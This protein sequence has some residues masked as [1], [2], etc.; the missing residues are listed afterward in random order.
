MLRR[1]HTLI[2]SK[3]TRLNLKGDI[4]NKFD[5]SA[6]PRSALRT[7]R[8]LISDKPPDR[9]SALALCCW[10]TAIPSTLTSHTLAQFPC[11]P[12]PQHWF[13]FYFLSFSPSL[14]SPLLFTHLL[15]ALS[16]NSVFFTSLLIFPL[17]RPSCLLMTCPSHAFT[18]S[19]HSS[20]EAASVPRCGTYCIYLYFCS[21]P[22][23][24]S[25]NTIGIKCWH[26][27][28]GILKQ[29]VVR[30]FECLIFSARC[31]LKPLK[32]FGNTYSTVAPMKPIKNLIWMRERGEK[33][34]KR[35]RGIGDTICHYFH[36]FRTHCDKN[37][38]T[39]QGVAHTGTLQT[40][41]YAHTHQLWVWFAMCSFCL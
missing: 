27:L 19:S 15:P 28:L 31:W 1:T 41:K 21:S 4:R 3:S 16:L 11:I 18:V 32:C 40:N 29:A 39:H 6:Y 14:F 26:D 35:G 25:F 17:L 13:F 34:K 10:F 9:I 8:N 38:Y 30:L 12:P 37:K 2:C 24:E 22:L 33:G 20:G 36:S 5:T 23:S 7:K